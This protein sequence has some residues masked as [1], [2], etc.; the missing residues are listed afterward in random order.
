MA[1]KKGKKKV[2]KKSKSAKVAAAKKSVQNKGILKHKKI[3][4]KALRGK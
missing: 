3:I 1:G 2:T 4:K